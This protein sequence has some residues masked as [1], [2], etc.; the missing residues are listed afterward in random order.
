METAILFDQKIDIAKEWRTEA[1]EGSS[2]SAI[3]QTLEK[4][5]R[6]HSRKRSF[7]CQ[8]CSQ[9]VIL[10]LREESPHFRH[11]GK[12]CPSADNYEK[13]IRRVNK[14][15]SIQIHR[16]GRA[17][18]RTYLEGQV[19]THGV[20]LED[21][22]MYRSV[23]HIV[24]DYILVFPSG[25]KWAIDYVTGSREDESYNNY[26]QKRTAAY[27]AAG[28]TPYYFIDASWI[29]KVPNRSMISLYLAESQMKVHSSIDED[30][31]E[32]VNEFMETFGES[33]V[34]RE[35]FGVNHFNHNDK[36]S[37]VVQK[38]KVFSLAYV[39]PTEGK[40]WIQR[41]TPSNNKFGYSIYCAAIPLEKA[42]SLSKEGDEFQWW[43][44]DES[45]AMRECLN[46]LSIKYQHNAKQNSELFQSQNHIDSQLMIAATSTKHTY[47]VKSA[48][49]SVVDPSS[50]IDIITNDMPVELAQEIIEN[51]RVNKFRLSK[52][53]IEEIRHKARLVMGP[54]RNP[55][56]ISPGLRQAMIELALL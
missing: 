43:A 52:Q 37:S 4:K 24:P 36:S 38:Y 7:S 45:E 1:L 11:E 6:I 40:T 15:E 47:E 25:E 12:R 48:L 21:G 5:Y 41:F 16:V 17:I 56:P 33:F 51:L 44:D 35:M 3:I 46:R 8:C 49:G 34:F 23:L 39:D 28:F 42:V 14:Q 19:K 2:R 26:I 9:Q 27:K 50:L 55:N 31:S 30:W 32:F 29:A 18:L 13:Y 54:I 10:V 22:Y 53:S 20:L